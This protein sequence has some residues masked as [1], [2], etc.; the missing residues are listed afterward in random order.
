M[1]NPTRIEGDVYVSGNLSCLTFSPPAGCI[2]DTAVVAAANIAATKQEH[3]YSKVYAQDGNADSAADKRCIHYAYGATGSIVAFEAGSIT[4]CT[5]D[6]TITVDLT[7]AGVSV[8]A[9]AIVLDNTNT[10]RVVEAGTISTAALAD[11]DCLEVVITVS[12]GT[13]TIGHGVFASCIIREK[14]Q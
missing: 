13:G 5:G 7:K 9:A 2:T 11:G 14:A 4:A 12:A 6:S 3:Q 10:A 8:L 1:A